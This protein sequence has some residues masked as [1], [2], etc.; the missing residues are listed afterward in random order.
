MSKKNDWRPYWLTDPK[1]S[2]WKACLRGLF[3]ISIML[4]C[5]LLLTTA[6]YGKDIVER[7]IDQ[8]QSEV[9]VPFDR[10]LTDFDQ[11]V[12]KVI[13]NSGK[14]T[15]DIAE[16]MS[17]KPQY[18]ISKM[19]PA[20]QTKLMGD[21]DM[22]DITMAYELFD[23]EFEHLTVLGQETWYV[24]FLSEGDCVINYL[25]TSRPGMRKQFYQLYDQLK[26]NQQEL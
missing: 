18:L 8:N 6:G 21:V 11:S 5:L 1:D 14:V 10:F 3:V 25:Y 7:H 24:V 23:F 16:F 9:C 17:P 13:P 15:Y 12:Q 19:P 26:N 20:V 22:S 4:V 2:V